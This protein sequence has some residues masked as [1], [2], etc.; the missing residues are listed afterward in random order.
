[1]RK[2]VN[3]DKVREWLEEQEEEEEKEWKYIGEAYDVLREKVE[4][5]GIKT[6]TITG[7]S[8]GWWKKEWRKGSP[9]G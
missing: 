2:G 5:H 8:K 3:W 7:R 1:M 6:V 9:K 4:K